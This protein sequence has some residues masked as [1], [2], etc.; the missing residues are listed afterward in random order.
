MT[1]KEKKE[2]VSLYEKLCFMEHDASKHKIKGM[3]T[4]EAEQGS[5]AEGYHTGLGEALDMLG[6]FLGLGV[7]V[8]WV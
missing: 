3:T 5:F 8:N 7:K 6:G 1:K 4:A 2:L